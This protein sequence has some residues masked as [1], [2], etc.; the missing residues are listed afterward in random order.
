MK[1]KVI[2]LNKIPNITEF[3]DKA[4][5]VNGDITIRL[6]KTYFDGKSLMGMLLIAHAVNVTIEYPDIAI[7]FENYIT[8]YEV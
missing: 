6:G 3:V 2:G 1:I 7:D 4:N 8:Q 5:S